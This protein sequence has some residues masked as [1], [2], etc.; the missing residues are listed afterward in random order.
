[1]PRLKKLRRP[2]H[3]EKL[4]WAWRLVWLVLYAPVSALIKIRYVNLDRLPADGGAIVVVNHIAHVDPF[5]VSKMVLD[6]ARVPRFLAKAGIFGVPAVGAAM[7]G[8]GHIPVKRDTADAQLALIP[9]VA[10]LR[11]GRIIVIHPEGTVTRDPQGWP[12]VGR[13][14]AARLALLAPDVPVIPIAQWGVQESIDFYQKRF[15]LFPRPRHVLSI[16]EPIDIS[17]YVGAEPTAKN[18]RALTDMFVRQLRTDVAR[19]RDVPSPDGELFRWTRDR[20]RGD[21]S[22]DAA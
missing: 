5:L 13:T 22:R 17:G 12:M 14:G 6:G 8:M 20:G 2:G 11:A 9:A 1:L 7:S 15:R 16:G 19:L 3:G 10:A 21:P 4:G 18:L